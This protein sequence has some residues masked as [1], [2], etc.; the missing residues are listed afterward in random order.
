MHLKVFAELKKKNEDTIREID[1]TMCRI[2]FENLLKRASL[3]L[4]NEG[5]HFEHFL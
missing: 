5:V 2:V 1:T 4:V 3:C